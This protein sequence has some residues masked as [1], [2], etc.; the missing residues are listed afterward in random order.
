VALV[1]AAVTLAA[2]Y[3]PAVRAAR[4]HPDEALRSE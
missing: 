2:A 1:L 4:L 3:R